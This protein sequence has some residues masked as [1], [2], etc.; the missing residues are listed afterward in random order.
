MCRTANVLA[1]ASTNTKYSSVNPNDASV[2]H[3]LPN[4]RSARIATRIADPF[5]TNITD[6]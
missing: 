3:V 2:T 6:R 5:W 4:S 1:I